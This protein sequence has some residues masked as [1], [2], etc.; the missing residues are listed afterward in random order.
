MGKSDAD[1][2]QVK[3][4]PWIWR[5]PAGFVGYRPDFVCGSAAEV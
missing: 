1:H 3:L 4:T 2:L 5:Q